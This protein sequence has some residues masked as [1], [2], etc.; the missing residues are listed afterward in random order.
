MGY[1]IIQRGATLFFVIA[2]VVSSVSACACSHHSEHSDVEKPSCDGHADR[3]SIDDTPFELAGTFAETTACCCSQPTPKAAAKSE[4]I[5]FES[6][7]LM[8]PSVGAPEPAF[9][10]VRPHVP[11]RAAYPHILREPFAELTRG[12]APPRL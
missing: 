7:A 5:K 11:A 12:R 2:L 1:K 10:R 8:P 4:T 9:T 3:N 6:R